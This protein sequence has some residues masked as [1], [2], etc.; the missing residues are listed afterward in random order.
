MR[1]PTTTDVLVRLADGL[2]RYRA[3]V[4]ATTRYVDDLA[5][6]ASIR[7]RSETP[8]LAL[9]ERVEQL[10]DRAAT[11]SAADAVIARARQDALDPRPNRRGHLS[12]VTAGGDPA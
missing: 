12:V 1:L 10:E 5:A 11:E 6:C 9:E 4:E 2:D 3:V 7:G 8:L